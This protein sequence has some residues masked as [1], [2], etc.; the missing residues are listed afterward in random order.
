MLRWMLFSIS[1]YPFASFCHVIP[2]LQQSISLVDTIIT[3]AIQTGIQKSKGTENQVPP[4][5]AG[6]HGSET[7]ER[8]YEETAEERGEDICDLSVKQRAFCG[9]EGK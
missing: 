5:R 4:E 8:I 1:L 3:H 7:K 2:S 9:Y 6:I